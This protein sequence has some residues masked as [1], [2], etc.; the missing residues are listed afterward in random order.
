MGQEIKTHA[1]GKLRIYLKTGDKVKSKSL[2]RKLFPTSVYRNIVEMAKAD[3]IMNASVFNTHMGYSN[4]DKIVQYSY[5]T[6]NGGLTV[7]IELIDTKERLQEFF[8]K[9]KENLKD[10]VVVYREVEYWGVE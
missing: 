9:H 1:L 10:K 4:Y 6:E 8:I 2:L 3:G 5:E 7:C